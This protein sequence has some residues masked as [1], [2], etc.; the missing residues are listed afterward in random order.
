MVIGS[1]ISKINR[2]QSCV[3]PVAI[4]YCFLTMLASN[5][6]KCYGQS[7]KISYTK[8][9]RQHDSLEAASSFISVSNQGY[10]PD[11]MNWSSQNRCKNFSVSTYY[12]KVLVNAVVEN[13]I[14]LR[15]PLLSVHGSVQYDFLYKSYIDTPFAQQDFQQH[16]VRT[17]LTITVKDKLPLVV[18]LSNSKSNSPYFIN[19]FHF[20]L[21]YD[22]NAYL[23]KTKKD[24]LK[25]V[26]DK[27]LNMP[28]IKDAENAV[29]NELEKY[30]TLKNELTQPDFFQ[31]LVEEREKAYLKKFQ[32][33]VTKPVDS[34]TDAVLF[35]AFNSQ[36]LFKFKRADSSQLS[37]PSVDSSFLN[38]I[39]AKKE[40]LDSLQE[41]VSTLQKR[42]DSL[43]SKAAGGLTR[44]K[45]KVYKAKHPGDLQQIILDQG[46]ADKKPGSLEKV[47]AN[48]KTVNIGRS[49]I[50]YSELTAWN[51]SLT[52]LNIEYSSNLYTALAVGKIDYGFRDIFGRN[53]NRKSQNLLLGRIGTNERANKSVVLT[54]FT[55]T[56][57]NYN[58][59]FSDTVSNRINVVGYSVLATI[60]KD[61]QT[62][63]S[64]EFAKTTK[65][66]SGQFI[67]NNGLKSLTSFKDKTNLG[68]NLKAQTA[69]TATRTKLSGMYRSSGRD[70]QSF[71]L[72]TYNTDQTA[73]LLKWDQSF[74][75][76]K[77]TLTGMMRKNDFTN[78][79]TERTFK[80]ST[81][82][83][84]A[85]VNIRFPKWPVLSAGLYPGTQLYII[86]R[87]RVRE[88]AYYIVN[89]SVIHNY[90]RGDV[91]MSSSFIYN[92]YTSQG[93]DT[94][95]ISY[96][97]VNYILGQTFTINRLQLQT[98]YIKNKQDLIEFFTL[99]GTTDYAISNRLKAGAGLKYNR[100]SDGKTYMGGTGYLLAEVGKLGSF[101]FLYERSYLPTIQQTLFP[102]ESGRVSWFKYF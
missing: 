59:I 40:Q 42:V 72:Y 80:T 36:G 7:S 41:R 29:R 18:N 67:Q 98:Q 1:D 28:E 78:P 12:K 25:M 21:H 77:I 66:L 100:V 76:D 65:P 71:S 47:L 75:K 3:L 70:F 57:N 79:F 34:L 54:A 50:N 45:Q 86:N 85:Q 44:F 84:S 91:N 87:E 89:G 16:T 14:E 92:Q 48:I 53:T 26:G 90:S 11:S 95:F 58:S 15:K 6:S 102:I 73:W 68:I 43:K 51:V 27:H 101:Q 49:M 30:N 37:L 74:I 39:A 31:R 33:N 35:D 56:K 22:Q 19:P 32:K 82:F 93:T 60:R 52:G 4:F 83:K 63:F 62:Q 23:N 81:V 24:L 38:S 55:G 88:N 8:D 2:T 99:D 64:A 61:E 9:L 97:G 17:S 94:G 10:F 69:N 13:I 46:M 5:N 20:N 96:E